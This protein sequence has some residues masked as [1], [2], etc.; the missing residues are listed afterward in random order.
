M[1]NNENN[2]SILGNLGAVDVKVGFKWSTAG[3]LVVTFASI[4]LV[5]FLLK[6]FIR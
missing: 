3:V 6:K 5:Y 2:N 1:G 4:F